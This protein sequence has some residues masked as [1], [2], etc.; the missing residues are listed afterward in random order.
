MNVNPHIPYFLFDDV[1]GI[2]SVPDFA[3]CGVNRRSGY[4]VTAAI[5]INEMHQTRK[6][7]KITD[8]C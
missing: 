8:N 2:G 5:D 6:V 3:W 1:A 7:F 4:L